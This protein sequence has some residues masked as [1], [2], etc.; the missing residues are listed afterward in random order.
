[1]KSSD[2]VGGG[3]G[4]DDS[5]NDNDSDDDTDGY[6]DNGDGEDSDGDSDD[7][8]DRDDDSGG[9]YDDGDYDNDDCNDDWLILSILVSILFCSL[10]SIL[11]SN[12]AFIIFCFRTIMSGLKI[13]ENDRLRINSK[14][15]CSN[16]GLLLTEPM[17]TSCGHLMCHGCVEEMFR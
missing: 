8:N 3:D 15:L 1:M 4:D 6:G 5:D 16:C 10:L 14:F 17:Q 9:D 7:D 13:S 2:V 12:F 11:F